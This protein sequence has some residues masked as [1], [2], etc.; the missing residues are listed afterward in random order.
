MV[1]QMWLVNVRWDG[2]RR[3]RVC[4]DVVRSDMADA[5]RYGV[6][7]NGEARWDRVRQMR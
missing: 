7:R 1:R 5:I 2:F 3:D 6:L 4:L